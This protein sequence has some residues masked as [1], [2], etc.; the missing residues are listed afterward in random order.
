MLL[1]PEN[2]VATLL[3]MQTARILAENNEF[4]ISLIRIGASVEDGPIWAALRTLTSS[5]VV[6][7]MRVG[8]LP[9]VSR[10]ITQRTTV[11]HCLRNFQSVRR[12]LNPP[13]IAV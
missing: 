5:V 3:D 13:S 10:P 1:H 8:F 9:V 7:M 12:Q 6:P 11:I 2:K 4:L